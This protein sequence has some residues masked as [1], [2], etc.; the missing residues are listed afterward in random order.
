MSTLYSFKDVA[1]VFYH[2]LVGSYIIGGGDIGLDE[3]ELENTTEK[4]VIDKSSDG[5]TMISYVAG[6]LGTAKFT[7]Q[8]TGDLHFHFLNLYNLCKTQADLGNVGAW[9]AGTL[10]LRSLL[11]QSQHTGTGVCFQKVPPKTYRETG[12]KLAWTFVVAKLIN[13]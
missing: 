13:E 1:G 2:P 6:D 11:D 4:T 8:Q 12:Q 7:M 10:S 3:V 5:S 9:A